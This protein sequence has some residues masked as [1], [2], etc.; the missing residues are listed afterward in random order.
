M[1]SLTP[2]VSPL[3]QRMIDDMRMRKFAGKTWIHHIRA[4]RRLAAFLKVIEATPCNL[5]TYR[6]TSGGGVAGI[7]RSRRLLRDV[8]RYCEEGIAN[9]VQPFSICTGCFCGKRQMR[10]HRGEDEVERAR[11]VLRRARASENLR[12]PQRPYPESA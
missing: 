10:G 8:V 12:L 11:G 9:K 3:R 2:T 7:D 1:S 5:E 4:V 6:Q